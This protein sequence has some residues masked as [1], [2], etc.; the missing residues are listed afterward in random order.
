MTLAE[1]PPIDGWLFKFSYLWWIALR[2]VIKR[3]SEVL[4]HGDRQD[5][6]DGGAKGG[7]KPTYFCDRGRG[8]M[9]GLLGRSP[10]LHRVTA[11]VK[12]V[13]AM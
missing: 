6:P 13:S 9:A 7:I 2:L 5:M 8:N 10:R 11:A 4:E 1:I 12:I 3:P